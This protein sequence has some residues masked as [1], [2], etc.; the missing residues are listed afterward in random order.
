[1]AKIFAIASLIATAAV[2]GGCGEQRQR[3]EPRTTSSLRTPWRQ[4]TWKCED[5]DSLGRPIGPAIVSNGR[6]A[7]D[8]DATWHT[9]PEALA[10]AER[11]RVRFTIDC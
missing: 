1:M 11:L 10:I 7:Q 8:F 6:D 3:S 2:S 5:M 9:R 4:L